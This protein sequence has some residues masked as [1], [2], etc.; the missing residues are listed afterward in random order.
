MEEEDVCDDHYQYPPQDT[1]IA[2]NK[3]QARVENECLPGHHCP[4]PDAEHRD[5]QCGIGGGEEFEQ[6][7]QR[8]RNHSKASGDEQAPEI[9]A[10]PTAER[11]QHEHD[12][13]NDVVEGDGTEDEEGR[14]EPVPVV[15]K[16]TRD[17]VQWI[18][19]GRHLT[20]YVA[21]AWIVLLSGVRA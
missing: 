8:V 14:L 18:L 1:L 9:Q 21:L 5:R 16:L 19:Y 13:F 10:S 17:T 15:C 20:L 2:Q 4:P 6:E 7:S 12:E 11:R 3:M